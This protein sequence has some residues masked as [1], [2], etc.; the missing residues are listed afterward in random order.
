[1]EIASLLG[2]DTVLKE[3]TILTLEFF[4]PDKPGKFQCIGRIVEVSEESILI[5]LLNIET[6]DR[7]YRGWRA[8]TSLTFPRVISVRTWVDQ[9]AWERFVDIVQDRT[10]APL[11]QKVVRV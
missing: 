5:D 9:S 2:A 10:L 6:G 3:G 1:M 11:V 7:K 8:G 4:Y